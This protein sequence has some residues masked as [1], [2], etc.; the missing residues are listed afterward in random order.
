MTVS[1]SKYCQIYSMSSLSVRKSCLELNLVTAHNSS[2]GMV[3]FSWVSVSHSV[4]KGRG[5]GFLSYCLVPCSF[6]GVLCHFLSSCLIPCSF[7]GVSIQRGF[8]LHGDH[9]TPLVLTSIG[10]HQS[11]RCACYW[12]K[13]KL[14]LLENIYL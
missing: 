6:Q 8:S 2:C 1:V 14:K 13:V 5:C 9:T 3:M 10:G 4:H 7:Q 11:V 12:L